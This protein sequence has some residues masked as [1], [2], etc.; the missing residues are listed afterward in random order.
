MSDLAG[1][2]MSVSGDP[3][4]VSATLHYL[5]PTDRKPYLYMFEP[6]EGVPAAWGELNTVPGIEVHN[7]RQ[8]ALPPS[9]D[10]QGFEFRVHET[11][12]VDFYD[13]R[14]ISDIYYPEIERLLIA[15]TGAEKVVIFDHT[16]RS[17]PKLRAGEKGVREPTRHVHNDYTVVSG[18]ERVRDNL[19]PTEAEQR[20]KHRFLEINVWRPIKGPLRDAPLAVCDASTIAPDDLIAADLIYPDKITET[21]SFNYNPAHR[22]YYYPKMLRDEAL[23]FKCF[24]SDDR[25]KARFAAHTAFDDPTAPSGVLP[26]ESIE[27]RAL[28]F[29]PPG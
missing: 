1:A 14:E 16:I 24:D 22:W 23:L 9:L 18:P 20:L 12:V 2:S 28:V 29:F 11:A 6:P 27:V 13:Q 10:E 7:A 4:S 8:L 3:A 25:A 5:F 15:A 19:S 26:R 17:V 21:Y